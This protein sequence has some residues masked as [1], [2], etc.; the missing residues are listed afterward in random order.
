MSFLQATKD[1][2][3]AAFNLGEKACGACIL[4]RAEDGSNQYGKDYN[5]ISSSPYADTT[6]YFPV[7]PPQMVPGITECGKLRSHNHWQPLCVPKK[8]W[9]TD[10]PLTEADCTIQSFAAPWAA[11]CTPMFMRSP[12]QFLLL[13]PGP[14]CLHSPTGDAEYKEQAKDVLD[15]SAAL[16][17]VEKAITEHWADGP[18]S[19]VFNH[20]DTGCTL[21]QM[22][23]CTRG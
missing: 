5:S 3:G 18:G 21:L 7:N 16:S 2:K 9:I 20:P 4:A 6:N 15:H 12:D 10:Q 13:T 22:L 1:S 14:P 17:D 19:S 23:L 8:H 11:C